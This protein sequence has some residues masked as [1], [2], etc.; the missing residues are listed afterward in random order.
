MNI[1]M[2]SRID[3]YSIKKSS[4]FFNEEFRNTKGI[5]PELCPA[6]RAFNSVGFVIGSPIAVKF[7]N[8][9]KFFLEK[10]RDSNQNIFLSPGVIGEPNS[11]RLYARVDSGLSFM[12]LELPIIAIKNQN[13]IDYLDSIIIP[14]VLYPAGYSGPILIPISANNDIQINTN[15]G[16]LS[17]IPLSTDINMDYEIISSDIRHDKFEGLYYR[18]WQDTY[19]NSEI[20]TSE[21]I[22]KD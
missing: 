6:I 16:L 9:R 15:D 5:R 3:N 22:F 13:T 12:N 1:K 10:R 18:N 7:E 2:Y 19:K 14:P 20:I 4:I 11:D 17:L 8:K 21:N